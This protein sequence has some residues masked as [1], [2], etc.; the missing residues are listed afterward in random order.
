MIFESAFSNSFLWPLDSQY[1]NK[2]IRTTTNQAV[3]NILWLVS[4]SVFQRWVFVASHIHQQTI[5]QYL[6]VLF[7]FL[8]LLLPLIMYRRVCV[9][10]YWFMESRLMNMLMLVLNADFQSFYRRHRRSWPFS[11]T[12][13][14]FARHF[15]RIFVHKKEKT[16]KKFKNSIF[17]LPEKKNWR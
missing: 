15:F 5:F 7:F 4:I 1:K 14:S 2:K 12:V 11:H 16:L 3:G 6:F 8:F 10:T 9:I 17:S 13:W